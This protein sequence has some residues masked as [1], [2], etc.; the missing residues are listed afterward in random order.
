[1][2]NNIPKFELTEKSIELAKTI[3]DESKREVCLVSTVAFAEKYLNENE[4]NRIL[5]G[6]KMIGTNV[7]NKLIKEEIEEEREKGE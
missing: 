5:E 3:E 4:I 6:I 7:I 2:R 1:M